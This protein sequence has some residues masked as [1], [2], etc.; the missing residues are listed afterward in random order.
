MKE[1]MF[2]LIMFMLVVDTVADLIEKRDTR[3][4]KLREILTGE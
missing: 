1:W 4:E 2:W 3:F